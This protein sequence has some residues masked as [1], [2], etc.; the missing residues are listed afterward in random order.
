M[1]DFACR[2]FDLNDIMKCGLGL[3]KSEFILFEH[4]TKNN[5]REWTTISLSNKLG[6]NLTTIQ[7]GVKKLNELGIILRHQK[8]L[9]NGGYIYTYECNSKQKIR[10]VLKNI[11]DNW[12]SKVHQEIDQW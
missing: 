7:K 3:T 9:E 8:N 1:I 4:F 12:S 10:K 6:L 11:I 2:E 5:E